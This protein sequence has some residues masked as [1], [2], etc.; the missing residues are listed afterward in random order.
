MVIRFDALGEEVTYKSKVLFINGKYNIFNNMLCDGIKA[1]YCKLTLSISPE[2]MEEFGLTDEDMRTAGTDTIEEFMELNKIP[3]ITGTRVCIV[4]FS[5]LNKKQ[6]EWISK[7]MKNPSDIAM[8]V[9][10]LRNFK[11]AMPYL[12]NKFIMQS[13]KVNII[14]LSFPRRDTLKKIIKSEL[15]GFDID[16]KALELFMWK[17]SDSYEMYSEAFDKVRISEVKKIDYSLMNE[18]LS[19]IDNYTIEDFMKMLLNPPRKP[20]GRPRNIYKALRYLLDDKGARLVVS[21]VY[22]STQLLIEMRL[23]MNSGYVASGLKFNITEFK[24]GLPENSKI[25]GLSDHAI[26]KYFRLAGMVSLRDLM[27]LKMMIENTRLGKYDDIGYERLLYTM[28]NR[29]TFEEERVLNDIG[30]KD[31]VDEQLFNVNTAHLIGQ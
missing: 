21:S 12:R 7:Y 29:C 19:D 28:I 27:V 3:S 14:N 11:D 20:K 18:L 23:L 31:L 25:K 4:D 9:V 5:V 13:D 6:K 10:V 26:M 15:C 1:R 17:L 30:I 2:T 8:L 24:D 22:K 16:N